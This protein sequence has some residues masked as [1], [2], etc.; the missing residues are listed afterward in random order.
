M[1][2]VLTYPG[3]YV[4]ELPSGVRTITGVGT[5]ITAFVGYTA[6][7]P[8]DTPV[9]IFNFGDYTRAFGGLNRDSDLSYAVQQF[10]QNGGGDAYVV[11]VA[12]GAVAATVG[13]QDLAGDLVLTATAASKGVWG[14]AVRLDVDYA[15]ASPYSTF[16]LVVSRVDATEKAV[17]TEEFRGLSMNSAAPNYAVDVVNA[18]S[19]LVRLTRMVASDATGFPTAG[20]SLSGSLAPFGPTLT[21]S[22]TTIKGVLD[23]TKPFELTLGLPVGNM[24]QALGSLTA[25]INT[26]GL[27]GK[28]SANEA[29]A[30]G[31][32]TAG[33]GFI[34]LRSTIPAGGH[35]EKSSVV[36][37]PAAS[38]DGSA[39][40]KF[41][42]GN[43]GREVEGAAPRRPAPTGLLGG[44]LPTANVAGTN[45]LAGAMTT[46]T[47]GGGSVSLASFPQTNFGVISPGPGLAAQVQAF[48]RNGFGTPLG[49]RVAVTQVG[50]RLQ[51]R[52][53]EGTPH[54]MVAFTVPGTGGATA[55]E[56]VAGTGIVPNVRRYALGVGV[57]AG[58]QVAGVP[59]NDGNLP[60]GNDYVGDEAGKRGIYALRDVDLFNLLCL[61]GSPRL[62][63]AAQS[64]VLQKAVTLCTDERAFLIMD[65]PENATR[66]TVAAWATGVTTSSYAAVY[67]PRIMASD[68]L[69]QFRVRPMPASGAIAGVMARTDAERGVWKA[70]A[71]TDA[72]LRGTQGL[73]YQLTDMENGPL[74]KVAVNALRTFPAFGSVVWGARTRAGNDDTPS[75]Y[76]Y[77]P[78]R[79]LALYLEE[80]LFRGTQWVVFEPNAEPLWAQIRL[81]VGAF[82]N[83]LFRQG[84]FKGTT[85][86]QAYLVRCDAT[87]TT[88]NDID[89]GI[90]RIV[91]G[92]APLKP[93]EFVI[94]QIQQLAGQVAV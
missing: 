31:A 33:G 3:V 29:N 49:D 93:A 6:S 77:V 72:S 17:E 27:T 35:G 65:P 51:L 92:F 4:E 18:G 38:N 19:R 69:E 90:V 81:N 20:Y 16:N 21:A 87:T 9:R 78:V 28:L 8:L 41:G 26:A 52:L 46:A 89:L 22:Q 23:G 82:M 86:A 2:S 73:A 5:S 43:G 84:A 60:D 79:R 45:K 32:N 71:G 80:S 34:V 1:P 10:F 62:I 67:W 54:D 25:A 91:V 68:P 53:L 47:P 88:Q 50:N 15:T 74:N 85:P 64:D 12:N 83:N 40:L 48:V 44:E 66:E 63:P 59:G 76:K 13:L 37:V 57:T 11:R 55:L 61:P 7:G 75:D 58:A 39:R 42:V 56:L 24:G 70:P 30:A 36:I 94:L 14:N